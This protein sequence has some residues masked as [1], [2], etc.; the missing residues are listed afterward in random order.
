MLDGATPGPWSSAD[1]ALAVALTAY[2]DDLHDCG[3][4]LSVTS[5]K[6]LRMQ[7][8]SPAPRRCYACDQRER[9]AKPYLEQDGQHRPKSLLFPIDLTPRGRAYLDGDID[10]PR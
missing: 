3:W 5:D 7:W 9:G 10:D 1:S 8:I 2:E 6:K 4:P